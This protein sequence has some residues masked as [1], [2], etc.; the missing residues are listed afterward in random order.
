MEI[1]PNNNPIDPP[2]RR[3]QAELQ[4]AKT[5]ERSDDSAPVSSG[6]DALAPSTEE[7]LAYVDTLKKM[8]PSNLHKL[9]DLR[10]RI[11]SGAYTADAHDMVDALMELLG[12]DGSAA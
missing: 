5:A 2:A 4:A 9:D 7:L 11:A 8:D 10:Q 6:P 12:E 3:R 1:R